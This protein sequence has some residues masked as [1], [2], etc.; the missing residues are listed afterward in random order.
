MQVVS[1]NVGLPREAL[2]QNRVIETGIFK[3]P[4]RG[5]VAVRTLNLEGDGQADLTVHGGI[6]K[7]VYAYPSEHYSWWREQLPHADLNPGVFGENLT[8]EGLS[9]DNVSIG[10]AFRIGSAEF[11][12]TEPRMPCYKLGIRF[13][14]PE[15]IKEFLAA[16]RSGFYFRVAAEGDV[17]EGDPIEVTSRAGGS[18]TVA[19]VASLYSTDRG[20]VELLRKA[21]SVEPLPEHWRGYFQHQ[22]E[23][24]E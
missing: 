7:A 3:E 8:T 15:I 12:V 11:V 19:E 13:D 16:G 4:V 17:A 20:N 5:R 23:K 1:V 22:L 21:V 6:S 10:D 14:R 2:W 18:I 24:Y 9:E